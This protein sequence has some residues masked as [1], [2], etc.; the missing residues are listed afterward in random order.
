MSESTQITNMSIELARPWM[1]WA[2]LALFP[3]V[4]YFWKSLSDFPTWQRQVSLA[5][6]SLIVCSLVLALAG[7]TLLQ[8]T[9]QMFVVLAV[10]RSQS[11]DAEASA[12]ID[13]FIK[14]TAEAR[15][16]NDLAVM[17]FASGSG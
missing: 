6:R 3:I 4:Y 9:K 7:L 15:G 2:L 14:Q 12:K 8:P 10:D 13:E 1:L 17:D 5:T 16:S 11:V